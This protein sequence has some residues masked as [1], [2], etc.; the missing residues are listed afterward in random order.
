MDG[1]L[2][3][4]K[5]TKKAA[6][7]TLHYRQNL[8]MLINTCLFVSTSNCCQIDTISIFMW[9][10]LAVCFQSNGLFFRK[11]AHLEINTVGLVIRVHLI[12]NTRP[13]SPVTQ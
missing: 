6:A 3:R 1:V 11:F 13:L 8:I 4:Q 9:S 5:I 10:I 12:P 7:G 2:Q